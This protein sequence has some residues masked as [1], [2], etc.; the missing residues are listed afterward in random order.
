MYKGLG[1]IPSPVKVQS[2]NQPNLLCFLTSENTAGSS[3]QEDIVRTP[4]GQLHDLQHPASRL[5]KINICFWSHPVHGI[6]LQQAKLTDVES[7]YV[8][9]VCG[10]SV[11]HSPGSWDLPLPSSVFEKVSFLMSGVAPCKGGW[12]LTACLYSVRTQPFSWHGNCFFPLF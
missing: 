3:W 12:Q 5:W 6:L 1:S 2:A 11:H 7:V 10:G 8:Q 9:G 4:A